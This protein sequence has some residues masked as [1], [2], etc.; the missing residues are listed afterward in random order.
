MCLRLEPVPILAMPK[1][2]PRQL[3]AATHKNQG[4]SDSFP[5]RFVPLPRTCPR[6][7]LEH[8][9]DKCYSVKA[10]DNSPAH[11]HPHMHA[12]THTRTVGVCNKL[13]MLH[14]LQVADAFA[15]TTRSLRPNIWSTLVPLS[16]KFIGT[17]QGW[18]RQRL[19]K[20]LPL[21]RAHCFY[22]K[23]AEHGRQRQSH[24]RKQK[25]TRIRKRVSV[26]AINC[27]C[28]IG[29]DGVRWEHLMTPWY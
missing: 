25:V 27:G 28:L 23:Y 12:H 8:C 14:L 24:N 1:L 11:T 21:S 13:T 7:L 6:G 10:V 17:I 22:M 5:T 2:A 20:S 16:L 3:S 4:S 15:Q 18:C 19:E 9:S 26:R 29:H